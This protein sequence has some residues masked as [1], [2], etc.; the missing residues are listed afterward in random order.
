[1]ARFLFLTWNGS[2]NQPPAIALAQELESRGHDAIFAGYED[3]RALLTGKGFEFLPFSLSASKWAE[4]SEITL[5]AGI[6]Y[7]LATSDHMS[8][9]PEAAERTAADL[10]IADCMM[11]GA[12]AAAELAD[13]PAVN[14]VHHPPGAAFAPGSPIEAMLLPPTNGIREKAGLAPVSSA[15][16]AWGRLPTFSCTIKELDP[17][18]EQV[19]ATF[20]YHGPYF[21][22]M[23]PSGWVSPWRADDTRPLVLVSCSQ[24]QVWDQTSRIQNTLDGLADTPCRVL[25][26]AGPT[27]IAPLRVPENAIVVERIP[28]LEVMSQVSVLVTHAG[29]GTVA[30][31]LAH[32]VPIVALPNAGS[33]QSA[34]AKRVERLGAGI[35]LDGDAATAAEIGAAVSRVLSRSSFAASAGLLAERIARAPGV[36][37]TARWLESCL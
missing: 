13:I 15:W 3:Q 4:V 20:E 21:E 28:H 12:L 23:P 37:G 7:M 31:A 34:I 9:V 10:L 2:G 32:G 30:V 27:D 1:L 16:E 8:D 29:H 25:V 22:R 11:F 18:S 14:Y 24:G 33:D 36:A 17:L 19:P 26:T 5:P 35:A 6:E